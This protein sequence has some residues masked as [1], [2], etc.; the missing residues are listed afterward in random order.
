MFEETLKEMGQNLPKQVIDKWF[1][2][3]DSIDIPKQKDF[4]DRLEKEFEELEILDNRLKQ[5][6]YNDSQW[7]ELYY[8]EDLIH[9]SP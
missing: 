7:Q 9:R 3:F 5:I 8:L 6:N 2:Q 1:G 4:D